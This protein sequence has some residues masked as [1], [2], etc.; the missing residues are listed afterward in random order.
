MFPNIMRNVDS[1]QCFRMP[2]TQFLLNSIKHSAHLP[3]Y[4]HKL[5]EWFYGLMSAGHKWNQCKTFVA[6]IEIHLR[7][8]NTYISIHFVVVDFKTGKEKMYRIRFTYIYSI[9][10]THYLG[11]NNSYIDTLIVLPWIRLACPIASFNVQQTS[12]QLTSVQ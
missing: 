11:T 6:E 2:C 10:C 8:C 9:I 5:F 3:F 7:C 1:N 4:W 12:P